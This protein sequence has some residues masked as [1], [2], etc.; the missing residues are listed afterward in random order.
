MTLK[1]IRAWQRSSEASLRRKDL[2]TPQMRLEI[3][4]LVAV[5]E[6]AAQLARLNARMRARLSKRRRR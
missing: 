4:R 6:V 1:Q 2:D 3:A 5:W